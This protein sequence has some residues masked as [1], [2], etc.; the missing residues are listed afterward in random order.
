[1]MFLNKQKIIFT[2]LGERVAQNTPDA[3]LPSPCLI[4]VE[5]CDK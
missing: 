5:K 1:M 3:P 2:A 4:K